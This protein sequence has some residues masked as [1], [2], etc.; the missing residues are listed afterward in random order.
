MKLAIITAETARALADRPKD[1][2]PVHLDGMVALDGP[3]AV[4]VAEAL[5][6]TPGAVSLTRL[7]RVS[8]DALAVLRT[9]STIRLPPDDDLTIVP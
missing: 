4:A 5:S 6:S 1:E 8:A 2:A 9:K 3:E 7:K